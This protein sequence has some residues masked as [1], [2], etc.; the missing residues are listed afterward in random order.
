VDILIVRLNQ[1]SMTR[2]L[3]YLLKWIKE[4]NGILASEGK[5]LQN[6]EIELEKPT[7]NIDSCYE[8]V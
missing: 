6:E 2:I 8:L 3:P 4:L 1:G 7:M 5:T